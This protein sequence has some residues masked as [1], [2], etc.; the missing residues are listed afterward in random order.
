M[1]KILMNEK[2]R[3]LNF[4]RGSGKFS[5]NCFKRTLKKPGKY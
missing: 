4:P 1:G 2:M 5:E 3:N